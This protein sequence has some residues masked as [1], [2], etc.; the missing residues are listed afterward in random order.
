[1]PYGYRGVQPLAE[2]FAGGVNT[3]LNLINF[4]DQRERQKKA[5]DLALEDRSL[6]LEDRQRN[7]TRQDA[8]DKRA[9]EQHGLNVANAE[10]SRKINTFNFNNLR[11]T[12][13]KKD[14]QDA[15][16]FVE[17]VYELVEGNNEIDQEKVIG[18]MNGLF[19]DLIGPN[20]RIANIFEAEDGSGVMLELDVDDG[21]G[22]SHLGPMTINRTTEKDDPVA[23]IPFETIFDA[24]EK[25]D[26]K[27]KEANFDMSSKENRQRAFDAMHALL[28]NSDRAQK[29]R[30]LALKEKTATGRA[31]G[32][33][34]RERL[35][36]GVMANFTNED[37]SRPDYQQA[38]AIVT[39][40]TKAPTQSE[41]MA[42][43]R[44]WAGRILDQMTSVDGVLKP[45]DIKREWE[46]ENP[47]K[48]FDRVSYA[49][50]AAVEMVRSRLTGDSKTGNGG[51]KGK[52]EYTRENPAKITTKAEWEALPSGAVF[53]HP[54]TGKLTRKE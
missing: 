2:G 49:Q 29:R 26:G 14:V 46:A 52:V 19:S 38:F 6:R 42:A 41:I 24:F 40:Q 45:D 22:K 13:A 20:K 48:K 15:M 54:N 8:A 5:D 17:G 44:F 7:I 31:G 33:S 4:R 1:M 34:E 28:G 39:G 11:S 18:A 35:I 30:E 27:L 21:D 12:K 53:V 37:G 50:S 32:S 3:G 36:A 9:A 10:L 23:I 16:N 43:E 51:G 47:G 25:I